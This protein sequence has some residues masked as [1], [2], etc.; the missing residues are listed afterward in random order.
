MIPR[1]QKFS[2]ISKTSKRD[3]FFGLGFLL[4]YSHLPHLFRALR[5]SYSTW[6]LLPWLMPIF[7]DISDPQIFHRRIKAKTQQRKLIE[8]SDP[9]TLPSATRQRSCRTMT[10]TKCPAYPETYAH[11]RPYYPRSS[12]VTN[13]NLAISLPCHS[14]SCARSLLINSTANR[15]AQTQACIVG[16]LQYQEGYFEIYRRYV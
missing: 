13:R 14:R 12:S 16:K 7:E 11:P 2:K 10:E 1:L 9:K 6:D 4:M 8:K 15:F 3:D 5:S